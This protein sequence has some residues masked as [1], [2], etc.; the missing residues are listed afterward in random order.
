MFGHT[1]IVNGTDF[2]LPNMRLASHSATYG[3]RIFFFLKHSSLPATVRLP[4][5]E[6]S[7][8]YRG[9][10]WWRLQAS[11]VVGVA[12][13]SNNVV[14]DSAI[15][16]SHAKVVTCLGP[17]L[18]GGGRI[19]EGPTSARNRAGLRVIGGPGVGTNKPWPWAKM[20][21]GLAGPSGARVTHF[22]EFLRLS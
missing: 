1:P 7:V 12:K 19:R 10:G 2:V 8:L 21:R 20:A 13:M 6:I 14:S 17:Y 18:G 15:R 11:S 3:S 16:W 5:N 4:R 22:Q 9:I